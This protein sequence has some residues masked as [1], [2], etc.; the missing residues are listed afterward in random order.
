MI[1][2]SEKRP[3]RVYRR[4]FDHDQARELRAEGW[5]YQRLADHFGVSVAAIEYLC[6]PTA[7]ARNRRHTREWYSAIC[8]DC[9][10]DCTHNWSA[11]V[12]RHD[13]VVCFRCAHLRRS[14]K[15]LLE[16]MNQDGEIRCGGCGR[17]RDPALFVMKANGSPRPQCRDCETARR[18]A[19][20]A[21]HR[22]HERAYDR[23]RKRRIARKR[24][25]AAS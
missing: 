4:K 2:V 23:E 11:R 1:T 7:K 22:D 21:A 25:E 16:R 10:A 18:T 5:T 19:Y 24:R 3:G 9:G 17:H 15:A 13:R 8:D 20:R 12:A 14:E 6:N